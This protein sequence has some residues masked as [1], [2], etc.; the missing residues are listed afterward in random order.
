M[1]TVLAGRFEIHATLGRGGFSIAYL[2]QD[3]VQQDQCVVKE[4]APT[5]ASR[6]G[7]DLD[8][9]SVPSTNPQRL[10]KRFLDEA[11]LIGKLDLPGIFHLRDAFEE[12]G[13]AYY[14]TDMLPGARTL[15]SMLAQE[16][17]LDSQT[18]QDILLQLLEL[19]EG[20]HARK[21]IHRD[22]KPSNIL[23][24]PKGEVY[25]IDFGAAREW[26][27]DSAAL[28]TVLFTPGYAPLEQLSDRGRRGPATDIYAVCATA[29]HM[30]T[31]FPPRPAAERADGTEMT[32]LN[33]LRPDLDQPLIQAITAGLRLHFQDRPQTIA[34][35]R[36]LLLTPDPEE[37]TLST[38]EAFDAAVQRLNKFAFDRH[39]CP[40]CSGL[41]DRPKPLKVG[42]CPVCRTGRI[43]PRHLSE[44]LC[45]SCKT[46]VLHQRGGKAPLLFCPTCKEGL[47]AFQKRGLLRNRWEGHCE[48]CH[49][50]LEGDNQTGT[51]I[52]GGPHDER[53]WEEWRQVS[54]RSNEA[55]VCDLCEVKYEA[56]LGG[57]WQEVK[58]PGAKVQSYYP[59]EWARIA[60]GLPPDAG[61]CHCDSCG[62]DFYQNE[63]TTTLLAFKTDPYKFGSR[64]LDKSIETAD[65]PWLGAGKTS[66]NKGLVCGQ[67][68]TEFDDDGEFYVLIHTPSIRLSKFMSRALVMEDWHRLS[69]GLPMIGEEESFFARMDEASRRAFE[70]RD[71]LFDDRNPNLYWNGQANELALEHEEWVEI[72][73]GS[74]EIN[75]QEITF[76]KMLR[77]WRAPLSSILNCTAEEDILSLSVSGESRIKT[78]EVEPVELRL[79]LASGER[80]LKVTAESLAAVLVKVLPKTVQA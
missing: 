77:R 27:A 55:W 5:G 11:N 26:H 41:L 39:Q 61:N 31:G 74:L 37:P 7:A 15:D 25:L 67:C 46:G 9:S 16:G 62:A 42:T 64:Y 48:K 69:Q 30:L 59:D 52:E 8:L 35:L 66:G 60:A 29:Y 79:H 53:T 20:V 73:S 56:L 45:P 21:I 76:G 33:K 58:K 70:E 72:G 24:S 44:R 80:I 50:A 1:G 71:I 63:G 23:I 3:L 47:L 38:L 54:G 18:A 43:L 2:A 65:L 10:R 36:T 49:T 12:L 14:V 6:N 75:A 17:R 13:T 32:P 78:F 57:R 22:I 34:E 51:M 19:L 28:Q 68:D 4:L 40:V